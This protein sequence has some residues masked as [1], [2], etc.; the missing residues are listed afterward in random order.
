MRVD[1]HPDLSLRALKPS[2]ANRRPRCPGLRP[3]TRV[4]P[5][6]A[7]PDVGSQFLRTV[8]GHQSLTSPTVSGWPWSQHLDLGRG[9]VDILGWPSTVHSRNILVSPGLAATSEVGRT[10]TKRDWGS[11]PSSA[12]NR[13]SL[14]KP[15]SGLYFLLC[16]MER[17]PTS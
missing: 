10:Q 5:Q 3:P 14:G 1:L 11:N 12:A 9:Q 17:N 15:F 8:S 2:E 7:S 6:E 16:E 4:L 13:L